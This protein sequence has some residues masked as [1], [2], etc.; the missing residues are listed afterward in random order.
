[1]ELGQVILRDGRRVDT[2]TG[3]D[4]DG[5]AVLLQHGMPGSRLTA[6]FA[7]EAALRSGV[8]VLSLSRPGFGGSSSAPPGLALRGR[9]ALEVA[10]ELGVEE[11]A[12]LGISF[13][14][15]FAAAT[16]TAGRGRVAAL[17][18]VAGVGP[19]RELDDFPE[20]RQIM[21]LDDEGRHEEAL[22]AYRT[23]AGTWFDGLRA[24]KTDEELLQAM[25][26]V[27]GATATDDGSPDPDAELMQNP[28]IRRLLARDI[29]ESL[30]TVEGV[31]LDN[32]SAGR[33]WDVD[34]ET[35]RKP[36]FLWYGE[37]DHALTR[38]GNWWKSRIAHAHLTIRPG[39]GHLGSILQNWPD[40]LRALT[41]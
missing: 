3:G 19:W 39:C 33:V 34:V 6:A 36:T 40:M 17:G 21:E 2:F 26:A 29:R 41:A 7:D 18:I 8:R 22:A 9:D 15:P 13:G 14:G 5:P 28:E 25:D 30:T 35:I 1:M 38:H 24:T 23:L 11:F 32:I 37:L 27:A 31:C 20:E 16:A 4:P 12:V 10:T